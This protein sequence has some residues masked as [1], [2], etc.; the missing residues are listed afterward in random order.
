MRKIGALAG[1]AASYHPIPPEDRSA[2]GA[3]QRADQSNPRRNRE[4]LSQ[5]VNLLE[6]NAEEPLPRDEAVFV[7]FINSLR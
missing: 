3:R 5:N 1:A 7:G 6:T 2:A 4:Y